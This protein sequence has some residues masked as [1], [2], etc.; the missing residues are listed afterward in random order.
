M[1][2]TLTVNNNWIRVMYYSVFMMANLYEWL[3][4]SPEFSE[5]FSRCH[6]VLTYNGDVCIKAVG[7]K[8]FV[9]HSSGFHSLCGGGASIELNCTFIN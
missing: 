6:L 5:V 9:P 3:Q 8:T 1:H 7:E 4:S 2:A